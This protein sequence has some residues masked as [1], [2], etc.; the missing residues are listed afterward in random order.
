M[1]TEKDKTKEW[2]KQHGD[3]MRGFLQHLNQNTDQFILKG[4]TA[5]FMFYGLDRFSEDL[6]FDVATNR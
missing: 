4:G 6:D 2:E 3:L 5:L 1:T